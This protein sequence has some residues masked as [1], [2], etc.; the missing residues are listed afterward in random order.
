MAGNG[1]A[2]LCAILFAL[3]TLAV[4]ERLGID[5]FA[6]CPDDS[7]IYG[8][9][10]YGPRKY[11]PGGPR[12]TFRGIDLPCYMMYS[13]KGSITSTILVDIL[14]FVD[15][16]GVFPRLDKNPTPFLLLDG[17]DSQSKVPFLSYMNDPKHKWIVCID[18]HNVT[19]L[20]QVRDCSE[21][22]GCFEIYCGEHNRKMTSRR[23]EMGM[24]KLNLVRTNV[25]PI[26]NAAWKSLLQRQI[27]ILKQYTIKDGGL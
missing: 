3:E 2:V 23:I 24:Y 6:K 16:R 20:W 22:N 17:H 9:E 4:K 26:V 11:F 10:N 8:Q 15:D 13:P 27:Q 1:Q 7:T 12:C 14:K 25:I 18:C 5:I 19:S 21:Q